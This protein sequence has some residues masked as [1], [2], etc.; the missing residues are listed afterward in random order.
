[1]KESVSGLNVDAPVKLFG[2]SVGKVSQIAIDSSNSSQVRLGL[3][4]ERGTPVRK[5][6]TA[7]L[8]NH[9]LTG[10]AYVELTG[11]ST[12]SAALLPTSDNPIPT[13]TSTPS[14]ST[15][16]ESVLTSVLDNVDKLSENLNN[17]FDTSNR[18]SIK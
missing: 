10:I 15:R 13:I 5:D 18:A 16:L 12:W 7:V 14:L 8:K 6:T 9:R 2:V 1:M 3:M 11:G 17:V 4:I